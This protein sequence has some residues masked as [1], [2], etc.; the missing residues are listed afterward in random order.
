MAMRVA[1]PIGWLV[2]AL[3]G[4]EAAAVDP[5]SP[6]PTP[7]AV[8]DQRLVFS[9]NGSTLT[10]GSGGGGASA[11]WVGSIG[12]DA[13]LGAG[14]EYQQ[15]ANAHWTTGNFSGSLGLPG[16]LKTHLYVEA[17]EGAGDIGNH[18]F[19]YN[20]VSGGLLGQLTP[21]FTVQLEERY[22]DVDTSHGSLP[23]LGLTYRATLQLSASMSYAKSFGGNL[24]TRLLTGRID[25]TGSGFNAL[26]GLAGG[27]VAPAVLNLQGAVISPSPQLHEGFVGIGKPFGRTDWLLL[28]DY[29]DVSGTKRTS[30]ALTCTVHL[31]AQGHAP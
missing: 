13:V 9:T 18:A 24:G 25:Y 23:K 11:A 17:H 8:A 21:E 12:P 29:Q 26:A 20:V 10:G 7:A 28:G 1:V 2:A 14:A 15:I 3:S 16:Q 30:I 5:P 6:S 31:H 19:H 27:P 4:A 22:I